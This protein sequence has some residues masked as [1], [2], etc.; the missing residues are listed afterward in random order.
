MASREKASAIVD[1]RPI[2]SDTQPKNGRVSPF[3][4]RDKVSDKG[5]AAMPNTKTCATLYSLAKGPTFETTMSPLVD[6]MA[7]MMKSR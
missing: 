2:W 6:I 3:V 1:S 4:T 5:S 7:I